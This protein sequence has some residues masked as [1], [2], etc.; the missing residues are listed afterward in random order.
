MRSALLSVT[1]EPEV[2]TLADGIKTLDV[3]YTP[4]IK[5]S[6]SYPKEKYFETD[7]MMYGETIREK[8]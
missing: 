1:Y 5:L 8:V 6:D 3:I 4:H 2:N 7:A